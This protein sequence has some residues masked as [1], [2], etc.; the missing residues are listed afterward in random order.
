[1]RN[2]HVQKESCVDSQDEEA[3]ALAAAEVDASPMDFLMADI[4][5]QIEDL[6]TLEAVARPHCLDQ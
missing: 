4:A 6:A 2:S 5:R 3:M 1:M